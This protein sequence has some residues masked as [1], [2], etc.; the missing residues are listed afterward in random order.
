MSAHYLFTVAHS[1]V[2][3]ACEVNE[4]QYHMQNVFHLGGDFNHRFFCLS[5]SSLESA[6]CMR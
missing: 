2:V 3:S 6:A 5:R 4:N 1:R